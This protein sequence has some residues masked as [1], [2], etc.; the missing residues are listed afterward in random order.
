M[1]NLLISQDSL[2]IKTHLETL[3]TNIQL[4]DISSTF[5]LDKH[6]TNWEDVYDDYSY[7]LQILQMTKKIILDDQ[8]TPLIKLA[9]MDK[10]SG[11]YLGLEYSDWLVNIEKLKF[12][13]FDSSFLNYLG[14]LPEYEEDHLD[15]DE[16]DEFDVETD[17]AHYYDYNTNNNNKK[18]NKRKLD[19]IS[20]L[21]VP[22]DE[23]SV[24][25]FTNFEFNQPDTPPFPIIKKVMI[26]I[27]YLFI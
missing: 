3:V 11:K 18:F 13:L 14:S 7:F 2:L 6:W 4:D 5:E 9:R 22:T 1:S 8:N 19:N 10:K 12:S 20:I 24:N 25:T 16:I 15:F 23:E 21:D 26:Y 17:K 27:K